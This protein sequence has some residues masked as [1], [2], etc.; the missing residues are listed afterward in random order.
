MVPLKDVS[1]AILIMVSGVRFRVSG[2]RIIAPKDRGQK[3]QKLLSLQAS[4]LPGLPAL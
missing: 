1:K 4:Q 3:A 2:I